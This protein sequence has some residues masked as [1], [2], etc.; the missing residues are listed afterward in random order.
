LL[1]HFTNSRFHFESHFSASSS[2]KPDH[3]EGEDDEEAEDEGEGG[4]DEE[5]EGKEGDEE[6]KEEMEGNEGEGKG[7][8]GMEVEVTE[9]S[10]PSGVPDDSALAEEVPPEYQGSLEENIEKIHSLPPPG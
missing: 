10:N 8:E 7:E 3:D 2:Q 5:E 1:T 6:T 9:I 4:D